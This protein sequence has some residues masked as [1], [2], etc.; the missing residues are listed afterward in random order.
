MLIVYSQSHSLILSIADT[1][2]KD[3]GIKTGIL[4][5]LGAELNPGK[6]LYFD[7]IE[8]MASSFESC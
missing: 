8:N 6:E 2:A 5:P 4:D 3:T 1:I 7:L